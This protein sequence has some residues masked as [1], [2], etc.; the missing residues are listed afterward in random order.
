VSHYVLTMFDQLVANA[1]R[2]RSGGKQPQKRRHKR[3]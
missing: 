1:Q 3:K 2:A